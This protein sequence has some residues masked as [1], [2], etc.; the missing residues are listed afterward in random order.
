MGLG[1]TPDAASHGW[2]GHPLHEHSNA[3]N[4]MT[5]KVVWIE[6]GVHTDMGSAGGKVPNDPSRARSEIL[7][8]VLCIDAALNGMALRSTPP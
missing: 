7:E 1:N 2:V 4:E 5:H 6:V 8:G 3:D